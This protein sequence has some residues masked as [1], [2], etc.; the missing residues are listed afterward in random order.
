MDKLINPRVK[1]IGEFLTGN[2]HFII[3]SYQ[4]GYRW[5]KRQIIDLLNDISEFQDEINKKKGDKTGEFYCLQP[6]IVLNRGNNEWEVIDGQQR[7][8]TIYILLSSIKNAL[9][10]MGLPTSLFSIKYDTREKDGCNS[11]LFLE[12]IASVTSID[13][14]N[15]DFY[16]MSDSFLIIK[17]W[18]A[19]NK[20]NKGDLCNTLVKTDFSDGFD[21]AN[22]IR[23][24]WYELEPDGD[25]PNIEFTKYNQGKIDL[26]NSE[27]IKA[28]FYISDPSLNE[29]RKEK[30]QLKIGYE[31]DDIENS[32]R[33]REFWK[34]LNPEGSFAN[35][36]E[37]IF[38][39][40]AEKYR[41]RVKIK[42]NKNIDKYWSFYVFNE[43]I[44]INAKLDENTKFENVRDFLWDEVK[45]Y[46]RTFSEWYVDN[47]YYHIVGFMLY[48][49]Y[50]IET[51]KDWAEQDSKPLFKEKLIERI[52]SHFGEVDLRNIGYESDYKK[53]KDILLL[54][55]IVT[56]MNSEYNRFSFDN[57]SSGSWS[58]EHIHAQQSDKLHNDK[59]R[60]LLLCEQQQYFS[61]TENEILLKIEKLL[62]MADIDTV[63][64]DAV[65][66]EIFSMYSDSTIVDS[67]KNLALLKVSDNSCLNNNI[68]PIKRDMIKI[69]DEKGSFI[70]ICTKNVFMKYYSKGVEQNVQW[71]KQD[72]DLYLDEIKEVL[73][74]YIK[75]IDHD[76]YGI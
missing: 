15:I 64:F 27:L 73:K 70:P 54:F 58:L 57:Y 60:R 21:R 59:Q 40:I 47:F 23:F 3:P 52:S 36:I 14:T 61:K 51:I 12:N 7:L 22:N 26:T 18:L 68:F 62:E 6:I 50:K 34:F 9:E 5:E 66:N 43:L 37:Y 69:L 1:S 10:I 35:H 74:D 33:I 30:Y 13:R 8:T 44:S 39:L 76:H 38:Q 24:I 41:N 65:Q 31:W 4:R 42:F 11:K 55:N 72:M 28:I 56:T 53:I 67:I 20:I 48:I 19:D 63:E 46:H 16:R 49:G 17:N 2:H 75:V 32:L 71:D 25:E 45:T 29:S